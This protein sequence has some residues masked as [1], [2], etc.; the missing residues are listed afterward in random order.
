MTRTILGE[1]Y[2]SLSSS[3]CIFLNSSVTSSLLGQNILL[4]TIFSNTLNV[5]DQVSH[6]NKTTGKIIFLWQRIKINKGKIQA[7]C[8]CS[9][10]GPIE[11]NFHGRT[12]CPVRELH[13]VSRCAPWRDG[14]MQCRGVHR[15]GT[16]TWT[17]RTQAADDMTFR[18]WNT[19]YAI[20]KSERLKS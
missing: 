17:T 1:Q 14:Y 11:G 2:R 20:L 3:L 5:S 10:S 7:I 13:A 18:T 16:V 8:F 12:D 4:R 9:W 19:V 15:N 6:P